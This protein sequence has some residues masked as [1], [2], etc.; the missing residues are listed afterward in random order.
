VT[1]IRPASLTS[2][3][4]TAFAGTDANRLYASIPLRCLLGLSLR[5][6]G[7]CRGCGAL[8]ATGGW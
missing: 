6:A 4:P 3:T 8:A 7:G 1:H 2:L 5:F